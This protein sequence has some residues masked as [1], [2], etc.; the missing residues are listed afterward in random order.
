VT[1]T[2]RPDE[3]IATNFKINEK[4]FCYYNEEGKLFYHQ[5]FGFSFF[6]AILFTLSFLVPLLCILPALCLT[7]TGIVIM[8][9]FLIAQKKLSQQS[10]GYGEV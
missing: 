3:A 1:R 10:T 9:R 6:W 8:I 4:I 2:E 7:I 5:K